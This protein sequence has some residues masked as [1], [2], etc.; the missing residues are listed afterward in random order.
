VLPLILLTGLGCVPGDRAA[1]VV[2]RA[3]VRLGDTV[4]TYVM[5]IPPWPTRTPR[6]L[7]LAFHGTGESGREM[8]RRTALN[9]LGRQEGLLVA[10]PD[11]AVGN[12]A[13][14]CACSR[15]DLEGINDTG[16]VRALVED[17]ARRHPVDRSRV[18]AAGFS[19][20]GLFV[21][22]LACEM[23]DLVA[24]VASVAA[25]MSS[26]LAETCA[27]SA[28]VGVLV[29]QGT[30]DDA[31]PYEGQRRGGPSLLGAREAVRFWRLMNGCA[32][33]ARVRALPDRV[34]DGTRILEE[35][36]LECGRGV[37]VALYTVEGGRH[38]WSPSADAETETLLMKFFRR[39]RG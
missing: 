28:P 16:F 17:V 29:L 7:L 13:E 19:Q 2:E 8:A 26:R 23:A 33:E 31:Y 38:T 30:L 27:P 15:A 32:R 35:R 34:P 24:A 10:Y 11:A 9:A 39:M 21:H 12:W 25:P 1:S 18:Y 5:H 37:E 6:P 22:R 4:R 3:S 20:G 14:G 36:W